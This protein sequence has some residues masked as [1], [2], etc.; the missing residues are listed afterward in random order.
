MDDYRNG[1]T[2]FDW[3]SIRDTVSA[4][5]IVELAEQDT[6]NRT[7]GD[8]GNARRRGIRWPP[9]GADEHVTVPAGVV[10]FA[11]PDADEECGA[12]RNPVGRGLPWG[13]LKDRVLADARDIELQYHND[14]QQGGLRTARVP[15]AVYK[16]GLKPSSRI[17]LPTTSRQCILPSLS[18]W[19]A[20]TLS[21]CLSD[22]QTLRNEFGI[23]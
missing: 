19:S 17:S 6:I 5:D 1:E 9:R 11:D 10:K 15:I 12:T 18:S 14:V 3:D 16:K 22:I 23:V 2:G 7:D 21:R 8:I 13:A 20:R 4:I